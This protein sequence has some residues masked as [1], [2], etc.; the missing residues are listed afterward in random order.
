MEN[1]FLIPIGKRMAEI[2]RAHKMTQE[3][4]ADM[5]EVS[6]KHISHSERGVSSLSLRNLIA[7][8]SIFECSLDY[9]ILGRTS[10]IIVSKLPTEITE[11]L[12]FG[13]KAQQNRLTRYL[14]MYLDLIQNDI[15]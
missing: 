2:R 4:L 6:P 5:L 9:L 12:T 10:N 3:K 14:E 11:I 15:D 13:T 7:F 8:C 1:D